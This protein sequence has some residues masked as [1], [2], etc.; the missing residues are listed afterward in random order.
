MLDLLSGVFM[1]ARKFPL[2]ET[3]V[4]NKRPPRKNQ[5]SPPKAT[6]LQRRFDLAAFPECLRADKRHRTIA[7]VE[8]IGTRPGEGNVG[9]QRFGVGF[10]LILGCLATM[11][12]EV[13]VISPRVWA[14]KMHQG[15]PANWPAKKRSFYAFE[16][17]REIHGLFYDKPSE[18]LIDAYLIAEY[19]RQ[20]VLGGMD[21]WTTRGV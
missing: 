3:T 20:R 18:G 10:G 16:R 11:S 1:S 17:N 13:R 6:R 21:N 7:Y 2:I 12:V 15:V 9:A 14:S 4:P 19:G 8:Q 5:K